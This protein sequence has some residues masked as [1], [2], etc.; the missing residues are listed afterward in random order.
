M[1]WLSDCAR[2]PV[3]SSSA[4]AVDVVLEDQLPLYAGSG[5]AYGLYWV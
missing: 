1:V 5:A 3:V 4:D 2:A